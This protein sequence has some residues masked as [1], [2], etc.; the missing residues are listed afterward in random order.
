MPVHPVCMHDGDWFDLGGFC[1]YWAIQDKIQSPPMED[2]FKP[3]MQ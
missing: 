3:E 2:F 1:L